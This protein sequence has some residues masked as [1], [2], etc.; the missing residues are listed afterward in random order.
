MK[1]YEALQ[2]PQL[3]NT[4]IQLSENIQFIYFH[5]EKD[6]FIAGIFFVV[7]FFDD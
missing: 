6:F 7:A 3:T 4:L 2:F 5:I 1:R